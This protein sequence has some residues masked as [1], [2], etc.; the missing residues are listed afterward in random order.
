MK[1]KMFINAL[2]RVCA[3]NLDVVFKFWRIS[4]PT[5]VVSDEH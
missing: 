5:H 1:E 3:S 2:N 4:M